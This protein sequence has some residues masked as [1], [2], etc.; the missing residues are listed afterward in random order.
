MAKA[1]KTPLEGAAA[2]SEPTDES[3]M[4]LFA[5]DQT[6]EAPVTPSNQ[7]LPVAD[8]DQA[9]EAQL[10]LTEYP[11]FVLEGEE[12]TGPFPPSEILAK[13]EA[14]ELT[15]DSYVWNQTLDEWLPLHRVFGLD[16][17][18]PVPAG[19]VEHPVETTYPLAGFGARFLAG[20]VDTAI[21]ALVFIA[22]CILVPP[23]RDWIEVNSAIT[24]N[25]LQV[26]LVLLIP[27]YLYFLLFLGPWGRGRTPGNRLLKLQLVDQTT[28]QPPDWLQAQLWCLGNVLNLIGWVFYWFDRQHRM[29]HNGISR[30]IVLKLPPS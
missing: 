17:P 22:T 2:A 30:T 4:W 7:P 16:A 9:D 10:D 23:F 8:V 27:V 1:A 18:E 29:L 5:G 19:I 25:W 14:G 24:E 26:N 15:A 21:I 3:Q 20:T 12:A 11:Y 13:L 6:P 28:R